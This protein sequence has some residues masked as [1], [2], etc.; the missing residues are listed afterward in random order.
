[1]PARCRHRMSL[2]SG[3]L[4][5]RRLGALCGDVT[6]LAGTEGLTMAW[7]RTYDLID[8]LACAL[9]ITL[10][11]QQREAAF[12]QIEGESNAFARIY[13][14]RAAAA[15]KEHRGD[16]RGLDE[17]IDRLMGEHDERI[18]SVILDAIGVDVEKDEKPWDALRSRLQL[19]ADPG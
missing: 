10:S 6:R 12:H 9:R 4:R 19:H 7:V 11:P 2:S 14:E 15:L 8:A 3:N 13:A 17:A 1:M 5:F 18:V 16:K